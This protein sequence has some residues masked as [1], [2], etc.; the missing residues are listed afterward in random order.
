[1]YS[2]CIKRWEALKWVKWGPETMSHVTVEYKKI[3]QIRETG[4]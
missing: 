2:A 4:H 1:M 3:A